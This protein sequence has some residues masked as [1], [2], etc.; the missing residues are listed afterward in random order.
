MSYLIERVHLTSQLKFY[1]GIT[2]IVRGKILYVST[3][4]SEMQAARN[5]YL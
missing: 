4:I 1:F 2:A 3:A 5:F